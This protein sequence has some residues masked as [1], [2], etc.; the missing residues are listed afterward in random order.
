MQCWPPPL[1]DVPRSPPPPP[2][3]EFSPNKNSPGSN[4]VPVKKGPSKSPSLPS[5][6]SSAPPPPS[7][8]SSPP[9]K[10]CARHHCRCQGIPRFL[11]RLRTK[12]GV[13]HHRLRKS[14]RV[15]NHPLRKWRWVLRITGAWVVNPSNQVPRVVLMKIQSAVIQIRPSALNK[16]LF[17]CFWSLENG[18]FFFSLIR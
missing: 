12:R 5:I 10:Y 13:F 8:S 17:A 2:I 16:N 15:R 4:P 6:N 7:L 14:H 11:H 3:P 9:N 18:E 1:A